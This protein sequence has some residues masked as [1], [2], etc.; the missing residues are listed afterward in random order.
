MT[1]RR[2]RRAVVL[3]LPYVAVVAGVIVVR[4]AAR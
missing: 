3:L 1:R 2:V 4:L